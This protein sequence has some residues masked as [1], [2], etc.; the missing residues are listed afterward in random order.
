VAALVVTGAV[1]LGACGSSGSSAP[2]TSTAS[3][4][5]TTSATGMGTRDLVVTPA[6]KTALVAT[7]A[8]AVS[9]PATDFTGLAAGKTYYAY[10]GTDG[11][12]W[13][14]AHVVP[15]ESSQRAQVSVQDD[16]AY[17]IFTKRAGGAWTAFDDGYGGM[18][19]AICAIVV[20]SAVRTV[21][22]WS[23]TTPCGSPPGGD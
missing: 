7:F 23:L 19:G 17:V 3:T 16:G 1:T 12:Y 5:S 8:A 22:G 13:A 15:S 6:T 11:L 21:W 10:N 4:T 2:T 14:G 18:K 9:L 20:P